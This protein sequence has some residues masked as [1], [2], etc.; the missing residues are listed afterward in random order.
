MIEENIFIGGLILLL[1]CLLGYAWSMFQD[2]QSR[3]CR[4]LYSGSKGIRR[5]GIAKKYTL[6]AED[7]KQR[8]I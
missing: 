8:R 2:A 4:V 6:A 5:V 7:P 1:I 3:L